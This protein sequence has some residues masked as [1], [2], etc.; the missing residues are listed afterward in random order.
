MT[1]E[2]A[3][4]VGN[5]PVAQSHVGESAAHHHFVIAA[6]RSVRVEVNRLHAVLD[7]VFS[8]GAV[9]L[10][11]AGRRNVVSGDAVAE[12]GQHAGALDIINRRGLQ[13]HV[14]EVRSAAN[15]GGVLLP[16]VSFAFGNGQ[17]APALVT[18]VDLAIAAS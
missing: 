6:A 18:V 16:G 9:F 15:V 2:S 17:A 7:Q 13:R 14:I 8:G 4:E 1:G 11:G 5:H 3:F 10:E 12:H